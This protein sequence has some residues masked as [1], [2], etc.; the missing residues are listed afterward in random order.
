MATDGTHHPDNK[1]R[2]LPCQKTL[3]S[4][5]AQNKENSSQLALYIS[6]FCLT[7]SFPLEQ[8]SAV[9]NALQRFFQYQ[10]NSRWS[11]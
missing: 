6:T 4:V 1:A 10:E 7:L 8:D 3:L 2:G 9:E 5:D 11:G